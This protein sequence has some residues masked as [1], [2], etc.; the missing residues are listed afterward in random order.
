MTGRGKMA[1]AKVSYQ[2]ESVSK[3]YNYEY[4]RGKLA[5]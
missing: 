1:C 4:N 5:K 3:Y 2:I